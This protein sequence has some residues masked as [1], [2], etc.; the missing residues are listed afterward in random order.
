M[1]ARS[2]TKLQA[3]AAEIQAG[4]NVEVKPSAVDVTD[5]MQRKSW[6]RFWPLPL[7]R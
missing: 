1:C 6:G 5:L 3:G 4:Y 7:L 2:Q